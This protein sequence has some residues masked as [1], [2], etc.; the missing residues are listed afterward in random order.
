MKTVFIN[1]CF[2]LLHDG[3]KYLIREA[4]KRGDRLVVGLNSD[5]SVAQLK[6]EGRPIDTID[7]RLDNLLSMDEVSCVNI[8]DNEDQ[9]FE[10]IKTIKPDVMVKGADYADKEITGA[11]YI[12]SYGGEVVFVW[13]L[14]CIST[15]ERVNNDRCL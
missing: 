3:H 4:A 10:L 9:L 15:T 5:E 6:G 14:G 8:F 1:G 7:K 13:L 11:D 12:K 2:D